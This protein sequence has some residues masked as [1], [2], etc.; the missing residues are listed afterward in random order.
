M[1]V[2]SV[3]QPDGRGSCGQR[4]LEEPAVAPARVQWQVPVAPGGRARPWPL[5]PQRC[6]SRGPLRPTGHTP[7]DQGC[8]ETPV[9]QPP[10]PRRAD[11]AGTLRQRTRRLH[12]VALRRPRSSVPCLPGGHVEPGPSCS[13]ERPEKPH[14]VVTGRT[15][16]RHSIA[17]MKTRWIDVDGSEWLRCPP[18]ACD[19]RLTTECWRYGR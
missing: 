6:A 3:G 15:R 9:L 16:V 4:V 7:P 5:H 11:E 17:S 18:S 1:A 8:P 10:P 2:V 14:P 12:G 13:A 19:P